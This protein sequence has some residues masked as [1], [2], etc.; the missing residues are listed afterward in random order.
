MKDYIFTKT[1][2]VRRSKSKPHGT[3]EEEEAAS[4]TTTPLPIFFERR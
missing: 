1:A 4:N 2:S 3:E